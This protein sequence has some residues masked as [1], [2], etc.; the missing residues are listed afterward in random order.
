M[1]FLPTLSFGQQLG[2]GV[3]GPSSTTTTNPLFLNPCRAF[4]ARK[5]TRTRKEKKKVKKEE[6]QEKKFLFKSIRKQ[7]E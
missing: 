1:P 2:V 5:G 6:V 3:V 4:A 7:L